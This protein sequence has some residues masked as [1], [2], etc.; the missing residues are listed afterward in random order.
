M[1][2]IN[3]ALLFTLLC[4]ATPA[5]AQISLEE[6]RKEVVDF[7]LE[8]RSY[9]QSVASAQSALS[10][11]RCAMLPSLSMSGTFLQL[12]GSSFGG[13][14]WDFNLTPAITQSI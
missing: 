10:L 5:A 12:I 14:T 13:K 8:L 6:Y 3:A 7:S 1:L 9:D 11:E 4:V 2:K